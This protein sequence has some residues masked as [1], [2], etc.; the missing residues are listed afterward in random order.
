[1]PPISTSN[2]GGQIVCSFIVRDMG[3]DWR[4]GA[5]WFE[6]CLLD[7]DPNVQIMG[8]RHLLQVLG[9]IQERIDTSVSPSNPRIITQWS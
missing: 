6:T 4:M 5:E 7:H 8:T 1:M 9:M 3:T 2:R